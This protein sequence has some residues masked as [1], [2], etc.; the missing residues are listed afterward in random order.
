M[1]NN[2]NWQPS[3][4]LEALQRRAQLLADIRRF[5]EQRGVLEVNT[6][7]LSAAAPT[8]PYLQSFHTTFELAGQSQTRYLHTSPEFAMKRLLAAG[9]GA[10]YQLS[11]VFRNGEL[12]R[13]HSPEFF[14]LEWYRPAFS[15]TELMTEV[16]TL[17]QQVAATAPAAIYSYAELFQQFLQLDVYQVETDVLKHIALQRIP[18][19]TADWQTDRDGW[20]E[21]LMSEVIEPQLSQLNK[22]VL[23]TEF[24]PSQ[25]QLAKIA[26]NAA[27]Q[28]VAMR[29]ELYAGGMELA[30][31]YD[32]LCDAAELRQR[33]ERDNQTRQQQG[34]PQMPIDENLLAAMQSGLPACCGVALGIERLMMLSLAKDNINQVRSIAFTES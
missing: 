30:N 31:G 23:V 20:L 7:I 4:S 24:P 9:S 28:S 11:P 2:P 19:L 25:A 32:E 6:P 1:T 15:L 5:F 14:M 26:I 34:K 8:A 22:P 29:F 33:F 21:M 17:M 3:A 27:G 18:A 13:Q 16:D 10:I 12:G